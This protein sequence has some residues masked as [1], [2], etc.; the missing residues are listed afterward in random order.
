M[1]SKDDLAWPA[2][3]VTPSPSRTRS[4]PGHP[5]DEGAAG[6]GGPSAE[7]RPVDEPGGAEGG[8]PEVAL[9]PDPLAEAEAQLEAIDVDQPLVGIVM[10][11]KSDMETMEKAAH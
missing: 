3:A 8:G 7:E 1:L 6:E 11:S 2:G 10:G 9:A 5:A 4:A